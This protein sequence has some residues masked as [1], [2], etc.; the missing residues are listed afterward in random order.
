MP[1][2]G[3]ARRSMPAG[4]GGRP[5]AD[6]SALGRALRRLFVY[7]PRLAPL[8]MCCILF[9]AIVSSIPSLFTQ[10]VIAVIERWYQ[11][12]DWASARPEVLR[13]VSEIGR[14]HV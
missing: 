6:F 11:T 7:Y 1:N 4:R 10:N 2:P 3:P 14:A 5:K 13:Y 8:T 12:G 9:S